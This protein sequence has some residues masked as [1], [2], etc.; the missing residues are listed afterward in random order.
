[1]LAKYITD[2]LMD[3]FAVSAANLLR[4]LG[5]RASVKIGSVVGTIARAMLPRKSSRA[6]RNLALAGVPD[7][8]PA[9]GRAW[10]SAGQTA[11]EVLWCVS[12]R[13]DQVLRHVR[14]A[15]LDVLRDAAKEGRGV[16]LVS[17]HLGNWEFASLA[18]GQAG[19]PVAVV[20]EP[21]KT[22]RLERRVVAFRKRCNVRTLMRGQPGTSVVA[23]RWLLR[24]GVLGCMMDRTRQGSR[25]TVPFLGQAA[26]IPLGPAT[27]ACRSGAAVVLGCAERP[28]DGS[29]EVTFKRLSTGSTRDP[30]DL[31]R[32]VGLAL[33]E[34]VQSR[35]EQWLW[36][37]RRQP[38]LPGTPVAPGPAEPRPARPTGKADRPYSPEID[39]AAAS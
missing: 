23:A 33:E 25:R 30:S 26:C 4:L 35:P 11:A 2:P 22:R 10:R 17:G 14:I 34:E 39:S 29:T 1:M 8:Q 5:W 16:L 32:L 37:F 13:P 6:C 20:A 18:A 3:F 7:C 12:Q 31:A 24:G 36:I 9:C 15:G 38:L 19:V 28:A 21:M 27:R